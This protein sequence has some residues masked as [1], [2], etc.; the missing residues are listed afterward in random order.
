MNFQE[1]NL[2]KRFNNIYELLK[3]PVAILDIHIFVPS[4]TIKGQAF[5]NKI[6]IYTFK[7]EYYHPN[8][9][10]PHRD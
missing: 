2:F 5:Y 9:K 6:Y 4:T 3:I 8:N 1:C 10:L 7:I